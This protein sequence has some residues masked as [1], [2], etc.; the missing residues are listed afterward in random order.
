MSCYLRIFNMLI[1]RLCKAGDP[2]R[3]GGYCR[4]YCFSIELYKLTQTQTMQ[5]E[6][7]ASPSHS[8]S[9]LKSQ[10]RII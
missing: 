10:Y 6:Y 3:I 2:N 4:G 9:Y 7:G 8:Q 5:N 1:K